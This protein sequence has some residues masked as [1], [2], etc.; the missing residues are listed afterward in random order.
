MGE[1]RIVSPGKTG[2]FPYP[3]CKKVFSLPDEF[4]HEIVFS[5]PDGSRLFGLLKETC[6]LSQNS[7]SFKR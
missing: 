4:C 2:G 6:S 7:G 5:L 1:I 3:V